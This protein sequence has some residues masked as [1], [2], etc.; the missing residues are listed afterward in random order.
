M[1]VHINIASVVDATASMEEWIYNLKTSVGEITEKVHTE[2]PNAS[3]DMA[4]VAYRDYGD[5]M[6]F[7]IVNFTSP[8]EVFDALQTL[9]ARGGTGDAGDVAGALRQ[10]TQLE[11]ETEVPTIQLVVH[12]TGRPPHGLQYHSVA[13]DDQF[14]EGD[15]EGLDPLVY[16]RE[17]NVLGVR[18]LHLQ[19]SRVPN[20]MV[21][22]FRRAWVGHR[23]T[24]I[25]ATLGED[26]T[27][28]SCVLEFLWDALWESD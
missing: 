2:Y 6:R 23:S 26:C 22:E 7:R 1:A 17:L 25:S 15:P 10:V 19:T 12:I 8:A 9:E 28:T 11:W 21:H 27:I 13:I 20:R 5:I 16:M 24:C 18:Y 14:P 4:L 3:M